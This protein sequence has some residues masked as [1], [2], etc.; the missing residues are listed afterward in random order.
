MSDVL[1]SEHPAM[2]K[3][4]PLGFI[5]SILLIA[6]FGLGLL[7]LLWW[8][9]Q[10]KSS[11]LTIT[12]RDVLYE[13]GLLSKSRVEFGIAGIRTVKVNQSFFDRIFGVGAIQI[14]TSGDQPEIQVKGMPDPNRVRE[15][16]KA[17]QDGG[18]R[19]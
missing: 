17:R 10:C 1:Y 9:L 12:S 14:Y 13:K 6:A 2:F 7:I 4:N 19:S 16:I 8:Y 18:Q 15:L 3:N 5:A 11:T